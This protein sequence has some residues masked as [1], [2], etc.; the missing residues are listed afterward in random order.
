MRHSAWNCASRD[1][2]MRFDCHINGDA[3][4]GAYTPG[5]PGHFPVGNFHELLKISAR[6]IVSW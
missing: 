2:V 1:Q 4:P 3:H 6:T 5:S